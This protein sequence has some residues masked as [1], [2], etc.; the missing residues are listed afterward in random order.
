M[1]NQQYHTALFHH[2]GRRFNIGSKLCWLKLQMEGSF[3]QDKT[4]LLKLPFSITYC[5][6]T[7]AQIVINSILKYDLIINIF[8]VQI[9]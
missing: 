6:F 2:V 4:K 8:I 3:R 9:P 5:Y 1:R 7:T